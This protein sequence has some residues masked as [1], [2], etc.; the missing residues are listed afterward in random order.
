MAIA[1]RAQCADAS[2]EPRAMLREFQGEALVAVLPIYY[3]AGIVGFF[4]Y[5]VSLR[6]L[7]LGVAACILLSLLA[8]MALA[9]RRW[10][11]TA[12]AWVL[13]LGSFVVIG[14]FIRAGAPPVAV[15]LG[16]LPA[17][18]AALTLSCSRGALLSLLWSACVLAVPHTWLPADG[19][20]RV[21]AA[22][23]VWGAV[24]LVWLAERPLLTAL[25]WTWSS[26]QRSREVLE[27]ARDQQVQLKQ[28]L[29]DLAA[30][31]VQLTRLNRLAHGL[32]QAA[33]EARRAK[34]QFVSNVSHEL[35]TPLNMIIGFSEMVVRA[36]QSYGDNIPKA[37]LADLDVILRN[38]QHLSALIDDVLDLSQIEAGKMALTR[39]RVSLPE[40]AEAAVT[41]VRP[42]FE[43]KD[44]YLRME[45]QEGLPPILCDR[46]RIRAVMLN[47]LSNAGRFTMEGGVCLRM[48][49]TAEEVVVSVADTGPGIADQERNRLFRPFEQLDGARHRQHGGSGLGLAI[50]K[51]FVEL[52]GGRMWLASTQ[53]EGT[54]FSFSLPLEQSTAAGDNPLRWLGT[55]TIYDQHT[56]RSL[57]PE[58]VVRPRLVV[59]ERGVAL[60]RLLRRFLDGIEV[61]GVASMDEALHELAAVPAQALLINETG[62]E[63]GWRHT[64]E[65]V[66]LP[67]G[68]PALVCSIAD[69]PAAAGMEGVAE[70]L[71]KPV[72]RDALLATLAHLG[73]MGGTVLIVDDEPDA[74]RLY[75]R[76]LSTCGR[77][78]RVLRA[79]NG[80]RALHS[81]RTSKPDVMLL[82][83]VMPDMD[84]FRLL[85]IK[86]SEVELRDIPVVIISA[87]D[88]AG[89]PIVSHTLAATR[90]E[91]LS[92]AQVLE[93]IQALTRILS[94]LAPIADP[95]PPAGR[96]G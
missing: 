83:L 19:T 75:Q 3:V 2:P 81:L 45:V 44:L 87:R 28:T 90:A 30:A 25:N 41:A 6:D 56:R 94:P 33:D 54:T 7:H 32:R 4:A 59:L 21:I 89:H 50:S 39:E 72:T 65:T 17:G 96:A 15:V 26:Y 35:R 55:Y 9:L 78:Y 70:Y 5:A 69:A 11:Q 46:T 77:G 73:I 47:L 92:M 13:V 53:G 42:L 34:E 76:L 20:T 63:P 80:E 1:E 79:T 40:V 61:Q 93:G 84:G 24:G 95:A 36:P 66:A 49:K 22:V 68:V 48:H 67:H 51:G 60:Q 86:N 74:L 29:A 85:D 88:P 38:S 64:A 37:L 82:D 57:A 91:G 31:N 18:L 52:H 12:A 8:G 16:T 14:V 27:Q 10:S 58:A 71:I 62:G 43:A 23:L